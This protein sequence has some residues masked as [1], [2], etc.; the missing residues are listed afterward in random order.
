MP[1]IV[2]HAPKGGAGTTFLAAHLAMTLAEAGADVTVLTHCELDPLALHFGLPSAESLPPLHAP[3]DRAVVVGGIDLRSAAGAADP[4]GFV[5]Q[6]E[7]AGVLS[8]DDTRVLIVDLPAS[9]RAVAQRLAP[10]AQLQVCP[11]VAAPDC[12]ALLPRLFETAGDLSRT[13]FVIGLHDETRRFARHAAA[14]IREL[15]GSR[16][17]GSI[18]RDEAVVDALAMLQPLARYAPASAALADVQAVTQAIAR[19]LERAD[20]AAD[21]LVAE[22][23]P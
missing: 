1:L 19:R 14:F 23:R 20:Y 13:L 21:A 2:C 8:P 22:G 17:V 10:L 9:E 5:Q 3:A 12:L 7:A 18:R 16:L 4:A 11:L 15:A 6:L